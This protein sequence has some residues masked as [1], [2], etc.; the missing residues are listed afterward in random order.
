MRKEASITERS[1]ADLGKEGVTGQ[2]VTGQKATGQTSAGQESA[3][4]ESACRP[5]LF[6]SFFAKESV[7]V[8]WPQVYQCLTGGVLRELTE[9]Y[10]A[11]Q[12]WRY[13][14]GLLSLTPA[15]SLNGRGR[16]AADITGLTGVSMADFDG[17]RPEA[18][19]AAR[20]AVNADPHTLLSYVTVSGEGLR[21]LFR[22][23]AGEGC[24]EKALPAEEVPTC[25]G[26][27]S[28]KEALS[29]NGAHSHKE[30]TPCMGETS[31]TQGSTLCE[32]TLRIGEK[33]LPA[34]EVPTCCGSTSYKEALSLNG[35]HSHKEET[36]CMGETSETQ[37]GTLCNGTLRIGEKASSSE[38]LCTSSKSTSRKEGISPGEK[39]LYESAFLAGNCYYADLI[40]HSFDEKCA[41]VNRL[42]AL[43]HDPKAFYNEAAVPFP[44]PYAGNACQ[45]D[46]A[47]TAATDTPT[48][49][50]A[51]N[52][53]AATFAANAPAAASASNASAAAFA[54]N[55]LAAASAANAP[56][57]TFASSPRAELPMSL[58]AYA[59]GV[60]EKHGDSYVKG[61]RNQYLMKCLMMMNRL[62]VPQS[63]AEG[64]ALSHDL[65]EAE[66]RRIVRSCYSHT[67]EHG[68]YEAPFSRGRTPFGHARAAHGGMYGAPAGGSGGFP[69]R[70]CRRDGGGADEEDTVCD[71]CDNVTT[72][73][74]PHTHARARE[75][76][77]SGQVDF[78]QPPP[79]PAC[80]W[81]RF[82]QQMVDC[83]ETAAQ[84]DAL[85]LGA[86]TVLGATL[87]LLLRF[88]YGRQYVYPCLQTFVT[89]PPA[90]GKGA[91]TWVRKLAEPLHDRMMALYQRGMEGYRK[92]KAAYDAA[93][94]AKVGMSEPE[95]PLLKMFLIAGNNSATGILE[96]LMNAGGVGLI[97][98]SEADTVSTALGSDYGHWS[99][100][101][102][103]AFDHDRLAY[104][105]R[106]NREYREIPHTY[107]SVLLSGTPAQVQPLIPS[108][109][110]GL[111]SRQIFYAMPGVDEWI[112]QF[113]RTDED[114]SERFGRW[115]K[116]WLELLEKVKRSV[117]VITFCLSEEQK[118]RFDET[119]GNLF[120]VA[121]N[122]LHGSMKS[123]VARLAVNI[124]RMMSV[125]AFLRAQERSGLLFP[126]SGIPAEN[127]ADG[128]AARFT[129]TLTDEDFEAVLSLARPLHLHAAYV[130]S[131]LPA[132]EYS[133]RKVPAG[134][135]LLTMLGSRFTSGEA[136]EA[137]RVIGVSESTVRQWLTRMAANGTLEKESRGVY[138]VT[139]ARVCEENVPLSHCHNCHKP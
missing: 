92:E 59:A 26:S 67:A 82:L 102:R 110:N 47:E 63:E 37:D 62:G 132:A 43:C 112:S 30:E 90:S 58:T 68:M 40:G 64:W 106:T 72:E 117:S 50:S 81:P 23:E 65:G 111:F 116:E 113:D 8:E 45:D 91:L 86:V 119:F 17:I 5:H 6:K 32:G 10:R 22:Y 123:S 28:Y 36:P 76:D 105:R 128:T 29:L 34:E 126:D 54:L 75:E 114:L 18:L 55:A 27:T 33:V 51:A 35:A 74:F 101:L 77:S 52:A 13:K 83:G 118:S 84:R 78:P 80:S 122:A 69:G 139:R 94:R 14:S 7:A 124:L 56:A 1:V 4:A 121:G 16:E 134:D 96:N 129:L 46:P 131:L 85:L 95:P 97:C 136:R 20:A 79:L 137:G 107:L 98:E 9:R 66:I 2:K 39:L 109:E 89:A 100:T 3:R 93:G 42:S 21:V 125:V 104:N 31:E 103:K 108:S 38:E 138:I 135:A 120:A 133:N 115:G 11:T 70:V 41:N 12:E 73:N 53:P 49:I 19:E 87:N 60:I 44:S 48:D 99:D 24:G 25:C 127:I 130:L 71:N 61:N 88:L 15:C 57:A